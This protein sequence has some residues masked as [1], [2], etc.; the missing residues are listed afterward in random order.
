MMGKEEKTG[1]AV[2]IYD[3]NCPVCKK[4]VE[5]IKKKEYKDSFEMLPCKS[6]ELRRRFPFIEQAVCMQAMQLILP[7]G[8]VLSGE[9]AFPEIL[10]RLKRYGPAADLFK[11]PGSEIL[12][13]SFYRWFADNRYHIASV[14]FPEKTNKKDRERK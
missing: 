6:E 4:T 7:D 9:K 8:Q 2:L 12:A 14:L 5:W 1:K 11:L 13:S 3:G 10:K